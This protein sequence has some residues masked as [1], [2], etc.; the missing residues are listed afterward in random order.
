MIKRLWQALRSALPKNQ[1]ARGVSVL[2][3]GTT[4]A[5]AITVLVMPVLTRIYSPE[6]FNVLAV[7][8]AIVGIFSAI[9][10]LRLE[11]A[12]PIPEDPVQAANL[13]VLALL[14][15]TVITT[16]VGVM[17]WVYAVQ[18]TDLLKQPALKPYLWLVPLGIWSAG[19][20][21]VF[22]YWA[23][24]NKKFSQIARARMTQ[25]ITAASTQIGMGWLATMGPF[26]LLLGQ[27][28][29]SGAG[30]AAL[31]RMAFRE[32]RMQLRDI[33]W[34]G[35]W[36][37]LVKYQ[38]YPKY[39]TFEA[40]A[41]AAAWHVPV[42]LIAT[43]AVGSEAG[44]LMLATKIMSV[45][46]GL[47]GGALSQVYLSQAPFEMRKG[48]LHDFSRK[49]IVKLFKLGVLPLIAIGLLSP[50]FLSE[51]FGANW[52]RSGEMLLWMTP[53][54]VMQ[55]LSSPVS[56]ALHVTG[57]QKKAMILQIFGVFI[58]ISVVLS[59]GLIAPEY[60]FEGFAVANFI[61]YSIY[62]YVIFNVVM[63]VDKSNS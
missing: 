63:A 58:N 16:L 26:G 36:A 21:A 44:F 27:V 5:Q 48:Q 43:L 7:F 29:V 20:Y 59:L 12:I 56:M 57:N 24:R 2:V 52:V 14:I 54:F 6:D 61:F 28:L 46:M 10:N 50:V 39:S 18:I 3:G 17:V 51:V 55:F 13:A 15:N 22:Q 47:I 8:V 45:P 11:I 31:A 37:V 38:D 4:A 42:I 25:S 9:C 49:V 41:N 30:S 60:I 19:V 53:W 62:L 1:F 34:S 32:H 40:L 35:M 33:N 23:V